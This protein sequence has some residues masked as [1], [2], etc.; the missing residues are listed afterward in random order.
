MLHKMLIYVTETLNATAD[1]TLQSP[2]TVYAKEGM[3]SLRTG[4]PRTSMRKRNHT[5]ATSSAALE[6]LLAFTLFRL[7][8]PALRVKVRCRARMSLRSASALYVLRAPGKMG[9]ASV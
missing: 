6:V 8:E 5:I 7:R 9:C 2:I 4:C 1:K 3:Y